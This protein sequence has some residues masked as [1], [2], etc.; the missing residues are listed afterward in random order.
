MKNIKKLINQEKYA[1][2]IGSLMYLSNRTR[3]DIVFTIFRLSR[4][5]SNP[6]IIHWNV[7]E[8][9]FRYLKGTIDFF[10]HFICY[11]NVLKGYYD[12]NWISY[13]LDIKST[14]GYVFLLGDSVIS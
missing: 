8:R 13:T 3:V 12:A 1:Q 6:S 9:V 5:T 10:L 4:Y 2:I 7:L 11:P 14:S